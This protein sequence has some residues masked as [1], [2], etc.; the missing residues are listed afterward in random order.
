MA[1]VPRLIF[2]G[3]SDSEVNITS[4]KIEYRMCLNGKARLFVF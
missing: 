2:T 4:L 3:S 1:S